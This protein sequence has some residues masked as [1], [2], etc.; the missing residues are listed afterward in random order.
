[1]VP[2]LNILQQMQHKMSITSKIDN[3][4]DFK[5]YI[6]KTTIHLHDVIFS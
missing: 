4:L 5:W 3:L 1:M 2:K 6:D